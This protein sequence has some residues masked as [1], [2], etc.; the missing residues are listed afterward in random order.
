MKLKIFGK[1]ALV[2]IIP[3]AVLLIQTGI[4]INQQ[5]SDFS[6]ASNMLANIG[7]FES[8]SK[9]IGDVQREREQTAMFVSGHAEAGEVQTIQAAVDKAVPLCVKAAEQAV[10][11]SKKPVQVINSFTQTIAELRNKYHKRGTGLR[12]EAI[13]DYNHLIDEL[14]NVQLAVANA[15]TGQGIGKAITT[16]ILIETAKEN[17]SRLRSQLYRLLTRNQPLSNEDLAILI[18]LKSGVDGNI[19]SPALVLSKKAMTKLT[20]SQSSENWKQVDLVI[21]NVKKGKFKFTDN[22]ILAPATGEI[23]DI[24]DVLNITIA[25]TSNSLLKIRSAALSYLLFLL[26]FSAVIIATLFLSVKLAK[27]ISRPIVEMSQAA[28]AIALG[29]TEVT[30][31]VQASDEIGELADSFRHMIASQ[32]EKAELIDA[33]AMGDFTRQVKLLSEKDSVGKSLME[34]A[35]SIKG[36]LENI[37]IFSATT[38]KGKLNDRLDASAFNGDYR[39]LAERINELVDTLVGFINII[40]S[41]IMGVD[42]D[43]NIIY[44]NKA[45]ADVIG[46][47]TQSACGKKCYDLFKTG[48]CRSDKCAIARCMK[49]KCNVTSD[50]E[51]NPQNMRLD[52][53]YTGVPLY[54]ASGNVS[55]AFELVVDLTAIKQAQRIADKQSAFQDKEVRKLSQSLGRLADG[56]LTVRYEAE[57]ADVDT[58]EIRSKFSSIADAM[59]SAI[60]RLDQTLS[61]VFAA[62]DQV[63]SGSQQISDASQSLSQ[64]ATEQAASLEE[65]SSSMNEIGSQITHNAENAGNASKLS[66]ESRVSAETGAR[67]MDKMVS[68]MRDINASSQQIAKVNK[69]IDDIAFQTNLL[70]LNAAVEAAR[71]GTHGKGFAV[72]ADEV[73]NLAG[74]SAKAAQETAEMIEASSMKVENG[75]TVAESTATAFLQIVESII[76][77]DNLAGE[78][79]VASNEQAQGISQINQGLNQIDQVTQQNTAY[80]EE[81]AAAS[82]ELSG[83]ANHLLQ[84]AGQFTVSLVRHQ[85]GSLQRQS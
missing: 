46:E 28:K 82:E 54:D 52:V 29:D 2:S 60:G 70:A 33:L 9:L 58:E 8:C 77:V 21:G 39:N 20:A 49:D 55:G 19:N 51:A 24:S 81:T 78:I 38:R 59:N 72:V 85:P 73:R 26:F 66:K 68:A 44:V 61:A 14:L 11:S 7:L 50:T 30:V 69:V 34:L 27:A 40:P 80:A 37:N 47:T 45:C 62:I 53:Q 22:D 17:C 3:L 65:I 71:A 36:L 10:L 32:R 67:N 31:S 25:D 6:L 43:Y 23:N 74:R 64:G 5:Y 12:S 63:N 41:P 15:K 79:A 13:A 83:Q 18:E 84:L 16:M 76:K 56:D 35:A 75:L 57:P 42:M 4:V 1:I 48:E